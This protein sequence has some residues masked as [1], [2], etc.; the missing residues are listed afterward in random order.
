M[1][2]KIY[3]IIVGT[4]CYIPPRRIPNDAFMNSEFYDTSGN[5]IELSN[6]EIIRKFEEITEI[7]ERRY[8]EDDQSASDIAY[9]AARDALES[10]GI[11]KETL[12][13]IIVAHNFG[14]IRSESKQ[15][16]ILPS[17]ASRVK[18][19]LG[20]KNPGTVS[21]DTPF[22][23]PGWLQGVI[24]ANYYIKSGDAKRAMI[25]GTDTLSK[26]SDP[27]DRDSMLYADG[28]GATILEAYKSDKPVGILSHVTRTDT[29]DQAYNLWLGKSNNP[30]YKG[31]ELFLK[32]NGRKLYNYALVTV[33]QVV[34]E[35]IDKAGIM[36]KNVKKI[37]IHQANAKMDYAIVKRIFSLYKEIKMPKFILP[38]TISI[39]YL[40]GRWIIIDF[41][42]VRL[43]YLLLSEP[44]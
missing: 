10:S 21:Y 38:M 2:Q 1:E 20:I 6:E 28:A 19:K 25:I 35:S 16:D 8:V 34:M 11:D 7:R 39:Y 27:H 3:T 18:E 9:L 22:G 26:I 36:L 32:M 13:Y 31:N 24:Q 37:L 4:G 43:P 5:K 40:P 44:A 30:K 29:V 33:P 14:D 23:C 17:L 12:D 15:I 42:R 41:F